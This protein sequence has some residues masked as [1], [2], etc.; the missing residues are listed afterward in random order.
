LNKDESQ[1]V[2]CHVIISIS[3]LLGVVC[4]VRIL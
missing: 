2:D 3:T 1:N 4:M